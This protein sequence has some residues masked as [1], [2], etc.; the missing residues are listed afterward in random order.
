MRAVLLTVLLMPALAGSATLRNVSVDR[1]DGV[2]VMDSVVWFDVGIEKV[3]GVFLD[4]DLSPQFSSVVV[5]ARNLAPDET[6]QPGFYVQNRACLWFFCTSFERNGYVEH[7]PLVYIEAKADPARSDFYLSNE[8]WE[9]FEEDAGTRVTYHLEFRP[10]FFVPPLI[11]PAVLKRKLKSR[12]GNAIE[13]IEAIARGWEAN[14][15]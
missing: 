8:R 1:V 11:G 13:R 5:E 14:G 3:F 7:E 4:W 9:F 10:K 12:S 15:E 6:G 2:Y